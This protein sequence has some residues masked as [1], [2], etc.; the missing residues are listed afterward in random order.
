MARSAR[1]PSTSG[2]SPLARGLHGQPASARPARRIIPARA[3]FTLCQDICC[4]AQRDHPRSRGVYRRRGVAVVLMTGSSPL[5]R[6]LPY[7]L[8]ATRNFRRIIPA[9]AGFTELVAERPRRVRDHP[10]SRGVYTGPGT[11]PHRRP[12]SSP[13]ARGLRRRRRAAPGGGGDHPRS[14][15]VYNLAV[16]W[17]ETGRGSSPLARGLPGDVVGTVL[18]MGIIPARAGF[19]EEY[20]GT[21]PWGWDHPRSRGVYCDWDDRSVLGHGSSP[22]ARGLPPRRSGAERNVGIIPARAGFTS[23]F[24]SSRRALRDH[25]RSRG[26]YRRPAA[27][28]MPTAGSSPLARGLRQRGLHAAVGRGII[29]ARAGFTG[30]ITAVGA[31]MRDHPRSRGVYAA[32]AEHRLCEHGS[33]PLARGLPTEFCPTDD[34][35]RIIPARAGFTGRQMTASRPRMDHPRSRGVYA[36]TGMT[37]PR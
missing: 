37:A 15:G 25:P 18:D 33:S 36:P 30:D 10:R 24:V 26:V 13:L 8:S 34:G 3:G 35:G 12:G 7:H 22:L 4:T 11:D 16:S 21:V 1:N 6:G 27:L 28:R 14:R 17:A 23:R 20:S 29:P 5:A 9:R 32:D 2:S 31:R 19:T